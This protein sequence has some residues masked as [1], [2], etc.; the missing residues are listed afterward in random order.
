MERCGAQRQYELPLEVALILPPSPSPRWCVVARLSVVSRSDCGVSYTDG[1][2]GEIRMGLVA[3]ASAHNLAL[4]ACVLEAWAVA[5]MAGS[6]LAGRWACSAMFGGELSMEQSVFLVIAPAALPRLPA[7]FA[8]IVL[9]CLTMLLLSC[10]RRHGV[11]G[12]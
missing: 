11:C 8:I 1:L 3:C 4:E 12:H 2:G 5:F 9:G 10:C 7:I 6:C